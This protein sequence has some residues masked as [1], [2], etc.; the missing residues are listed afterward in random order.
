MAPMAARTASESGST[1][2]KFCSIKMNERTFIDLQD[3]VFKKM[4]RLDNLKHRLKELGI[5]H[6]LELVNNINVSPT[7]CVVR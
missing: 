7:S 4:F 3:Y 6:D 5:I 2:G 1:P